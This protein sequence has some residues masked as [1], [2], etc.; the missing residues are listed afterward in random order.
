MVVVL[1]SVLINGVGLVV[2]LDYRKTGCVDAGASGVIW[3]ISCTILN[4]DVTY[5]LYT[6]VCVSL[7]SHFVCDSEILIHAECS[8]VPCS[9]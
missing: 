6:C 3:L 4:A 8:Q 2:S 7:N 9:L 1:C 5:T